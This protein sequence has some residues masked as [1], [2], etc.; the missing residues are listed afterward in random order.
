MRTPDWSL[1][2]ATEH[3]AGEKPLIAL[4]LGVC[5]RVAKAAYHGPWRESMADR[6]ESWLGGSNALTNAV[7]LVD[8]AEGRETGGVRVLVQMWRRGPVLVQQCEFEVQDGAGVWV[9]REEGFP[10]GVIFVAA[11]VGMCGEEAFLLPMWWLRN[12]VV[13]AL[14]PCREAVEVGMRMS[15]R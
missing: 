8:V 14:V 13:A 2:R 11:D 5:Q 10:E 4:E 1:F 12:G 3:P 15:G 6:A 9:A 7:V